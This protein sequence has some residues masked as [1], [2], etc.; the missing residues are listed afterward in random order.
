MNIITVRV[1]ET[2][3]QQSRQVNFQQLIANFLEDCLTINHDL[4]PLPLRDVIMA[5]SLI[6]AVFSRRL[7]VVALAI[8]SDNLYFIKP[9]FSSK[10]CR[11]SFEMQ[12][13]WT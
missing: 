10:K 5:F 2:K 4:C 13:R 1:W 11:M 7:E 8:P 3:P 6:D 9:F 12:S